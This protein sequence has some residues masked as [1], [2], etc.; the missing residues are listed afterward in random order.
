MSTS[1]EIKTKIVFRLGHLGDVALTTGVL[2]QWHEKRGE[3][4]VFITRK[5]NGAILA[6]NPAIVEVIEVEDFE[7]KTIAWLAKS[8]QLATRF[9]GHD[10]LDLHG[11]LRSAFLSIFWTGTVKRYP[12]FGLMRRLYDRTHADRFRKPLEALNVPQRYFMAQ[13]GTPP[14]AKNL[15]PRIYLTD[16]ERTGAYT[17]L[18]GIN[19][20]KS[21]VALH[22]YATH[23][24][25]QWPREHWLQLTN[26]LTKAGYDWFILGRDKAPLFAHHDRD[27]TNRTGL[28]ETCALLAQADL[29]ITGDSGPMHLAGGVNT[30]VLALFGPTARAWGFYP[31][32]EHD[33]VLEMDLNCRPCSLHGSKT[34]DRG[35]ECMT[36]LTPKMVMK[37]TVNR[38]G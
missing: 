19:S 8:K 26:S 2:E 24:A 10:L 20:A 13:N 22:P 35:F 25:K 5:G 11:T 18:K 23:P 4:Y 3:N 32:G 38:L 7:L 31:A 34:C 30:P 6:N 37:A 9:K 21:L 28:R 17:H 16:E 36:G 33:S 12:K 14:A 15:V 27:L 1:G 29:L